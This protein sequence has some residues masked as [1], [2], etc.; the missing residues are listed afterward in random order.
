MNKDLVFKLAKG[1]VGRAKNNWSIAITRL[2][3]GLTYAHRDRRNKKRDMR[4]AWIRQ[5]SAA[6][7]QSGMNY[8]H[9]MK[10]LAVANVSLNRKVLAE[11]AV[12]EPFSFVALT[13]EVKK[14]TKWRDITDR[15]ITDEELQKLDARFTPIEEL[16]EMQGK[17]DMSRRENYEYETLPEAVASRMQKAIKKVEQINTELIKTGKVIIPEIKPRLYGK[18]KK[19]ADKKAMREALRARRKTKKAALASGKGAPAGP[20]PGGKGAPAG[21]QPGG[22]GAPSGPQPGGKGAPSGSQPGGKGAKETSQPQQQ[23]SKQAT[24]S[25]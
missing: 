20:Q 7:R 23:A 25:K 15:R 2:E 11:L 13:D 3:K 10:G 8:S 16:P 9:F 17:K 19:N 22:K 21:P 5:I 18:D 4:R 24:K 12:Y 14:H 6:A 1:F